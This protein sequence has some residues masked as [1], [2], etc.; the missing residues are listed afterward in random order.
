MGKANGASLEQIEA[1]YRNSVHEF[2]GVAAAILRDRDAACDVVQD[3]FASAV[4]RRASFRNEGPVEAWLW[5]MVVNAALA[6]ARRGQRS[7]LRPPAEGAAGCA[8][9]DDDVQE[10]I[11]ALPERQR[12]ALFLR[13][14]A[15]LD[16]QTIGELLGI[17]DATARATV[18][19][20]HGRLRARLEIAL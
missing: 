13:Y 10:A 15:D 4:R 19:A 18:H 3:A 1:V 17:K 14:Y 12:V 9:R 6:Q 16:Y 8:E 7:R 5:R 11:A 2:R 20:A